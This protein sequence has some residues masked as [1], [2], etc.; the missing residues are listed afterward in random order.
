MPSP[1][2][3]PPATLTQDEAHAV[4]RRWA[5][6]FLKVYLAGDEGF[7]SFLLDP[8]PPG[9]TYTHEP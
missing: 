8:A 9:A 5:L 1:D 7:R 6:P 2:C 3:A 4:V